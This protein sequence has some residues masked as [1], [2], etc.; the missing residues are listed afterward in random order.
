MQQKRKN[1]F[2]FSA[3]RPTNQQQ[4]I[5]PLFV[6]LFLYLF[7]SCLYLVFILFSVAKSLCLC[8]FRESIP[9]TILHD[10][11]HDIAKKYNKLSTNWVLIF[12]IPYIVLHY[13]KKGDVKMS[14]KNK[15]S[16]KIKGS[17]IIEKRNVL[18]D[19]R[20]NNMSLQELRLFSIYLAK[21]NSR[22]VS[23]R[24]VRFPLA[25]FQKIMNLGRANIAQLQN[26]VDSLLG[27]VARVANE[28]GGFTSFQLFKDCTV[29]KGEDE[30]WHLEIDA[31]D[32]ALPLMFDFKNNYFTYGLW[33][34]L[35]LKSVN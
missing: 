13:T 17:E 21:I 2:L 24:V 6:G 25:E 30:K 26:T 32:R 28:D 4:K 9:Y 22:D 15:G 3:V 1:L 19:I 14:T 12:S 11:L 8:G 5:F 7:I 20:R 29:S 18:N 10:S 33:S 27:K 31:H 23:T 35:K 34:T 16:E